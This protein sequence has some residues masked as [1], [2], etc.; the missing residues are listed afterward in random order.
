MSTARYVLLDRD[1]VINEDSPNYIKSP[2]EWQPLPGSLEAIALLT[3]H[4]YR[5]V[6]ITNQSGIGQGLFD[7]AVLHAIHDKMRCAITAQGG[8][9]AAIYYCPHA[10]EAHCDCRKPKP[11]LLQAFSR[12]YGVALSGV[13]LIGD[14]LRD[15]QA[16]RAV[17]AQ[18]I[19]VQTGQGSMTQALLS[20]EEA[21]PVY[22]NLYEAAHAILASR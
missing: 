15:M 9:L 10:P 1:G 13:P 12:D 17:G 6:V 20:P 2:A 22:A 7:T 4:G 19:L 21:I 14:A 8:A 3:R 18:P 16:A 11:G 5:V